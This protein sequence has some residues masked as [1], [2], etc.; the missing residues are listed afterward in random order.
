[1]RFASAWR[2]RAFGGRRRIGM[3]RR[4]CRIVGQALSLRRPLR[5]PCLAF[6][7]QYADLQRHKYNEGWRWSSSGTHEKPR[8]V[9][10]NTKVGLADLARDFP[11][12]RRGRYAIEPARTDE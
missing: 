11:R 5:P 1:M 7:C 4:L 8:Q 3:S 12:P 9:W 10:P 2:R 6:I